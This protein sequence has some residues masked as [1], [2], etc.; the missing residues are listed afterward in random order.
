MSDDKKP[1][2]REPAKPLKDPEVYVNVTPKDSKNP[3][4][5]EA[6]KKVQKKLEEKVKQAVEENK[7]GGQEKQFKAVEKETKKAGEGTDKN[8]IEK[9]K[10]RV[11]GKDEDGDVIDRGW[12]VTPKEDKSA[13][14]LF[15]FLS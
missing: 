12:G 14:K 8:E 3:E 11:A 15:K 1:E 13:A 7:P 5:K 4:H 6:A 9:I 10:V 2:K